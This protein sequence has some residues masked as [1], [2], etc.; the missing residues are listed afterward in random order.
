MKYIRVE[1]NK[2]TYIDSRKT[3]HST[4]YHETKEGVSPIVWEHIKENV[5]RLQWDTYEIF[6]F[7]GGYWFWKH[8]AYASFGEAYEAAAGRRPAK[9]T[10]IDNLPWMER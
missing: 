5:T 10:A 7:R 9:Y 2:T 3:V 1:K 4:R 6:E 8:N